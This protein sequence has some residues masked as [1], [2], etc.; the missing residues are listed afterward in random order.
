MRRLAVL[1]LLGLACSAY[2][3]HAEPPLDEITRDVPSR[4]VAWATPLRGGPIRA[5]FFA[6]DYTMRDAVELAE[7][8]DLDMESCPLKNGTPHEARAAVLPK[9]LGRRFDVILL[10]QCDPDQLPEA[11]QARIV[12]QVRQGAGL[13]VSFLSGEEAAPGAHAVLR[14][15]LRDLSWTAE[16]GEL[17]RGVGE[18]L[19]AGGTDLRAAGR[20][21]LAEKGRVVQ[22]EYPGDP[23]RTHA[24]IPVPL[25]P[26]DAAP[27]YLDNAFSFVAR[28]VCWAARR[29]APVRI[30]GVTDLTPQG[31]VAEEIPPGYPKEF[32][33]Q[34][35]DSAMRQ[36]T[37]PYLLHFNQPADRA[38][39]VTVQLRR[40]DALT[41]LAY[42]CKTLVAKG[43]ST[44]AVD[45]LA[46]P[47]EY[48]LD[49][50]IGDKKGVADW[51]TQTI[52]VPG[53]PCFE[54][55]EYGKTYLLPNDALDITAKVRPIFNP[56]R[57]CTVYARV[58][59]PIG[60]A[61]TPGGR[62]LAEAQA[63]SAAEDGVVHLR[64]NLAD[65]IAPMVKVEVF[66]VEGEGKLFAEWILDS[67]DR[68]CRFLNVRLPKRDPALSLVAAAPN[69][70]EYNA[71]QYLEL[72]ARL[73]VDAVCAPASEAGLFHA[74]EIGLRF[75]PRFPSLA[76]GMTEADASSLPFPG[77][78][79]F[80]A[81]ESKGLVEGATRYWA[82]GSGYYA[83]ADPCGV[84]AFS[85]KTPPAS[86]L[87]GFREYLKRQYV[88]LAALES[89]WGTHYDSWEEPSPLDAQAARAAGRYA[90][91][92][93][94]QTYADS[95]LT[96]FAAFSREQI[97]SVDRDA[98]VG[99]QATPV[100]QARGAHPWTGL[101]RATDFLA[102]NLEPR[103]DAI[104][105]CGLREPGDTLA[106]VNAGKT[107]PDSPMEGRWLPWHAALHQIPALWMDTPFGEVDETPFNAALAADGRPTPFF[108][109]LSSSMEELTAG[110]AAL[111]QAAQRLPGG[112][113]LCE[114]RA[115][116]HLHDAEGR[117]MSPRDAQAR[118]AAALDRI[119][120]EYSVIDSGQLRERLAAAHVLILPMT[121]A[122]SD[123]EVA[124]ILEF[125][126]RGGCVVADVAPGVYNE[127][128]VPRANPPLDALFG[129]RHGR[130]TAPVHGEAEIAWSSGKKQ[131][132]TVLEQVE[133]DGAT[134]V[135]TGM[136]M[137]RAKETPVWIRAAGAPHLLLNHT[138]PDWER[139]GRGIELL[140]DVLAAAGAPPAFEIHTRGGRPFQG[141]RM[142]FRFGDAEIFAVLA[143]PS[144]PEQRIR[145]PFSK[146]ETVYDL[147]AG[148]RVHKPHKMTV[149]L[150]PGE[151]CCFA[152]L[153]YRVD[154]L[155]VVT[156]GGVLAGKRLP[157]KVALSAKEGW[158]SDHLVCIDLLPDKGSAIPHYRRC[159]RCGKGAGETFLPLA[160]N[161]TPG[162]YRLRVRDVLS[163]VEQ[164]R[165]VG[166]SGVKRQGG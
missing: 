39:R 75:I 82:G 106:L 86:C 4:H 95:E 56:N 62:L 165:R 26:V 10:G 120:V 93:D 135:E 58:M 83:M 102:V 21:A 161:E 104:Q 146:K 88:E 109:A 141:E 103:A 151:A 145:L 54:S 96:D 23:P 53:W 7:R 63:A 138:A 101:S 51:F 130:A 36:P 139:D 163:G 80:R 115:S 77:D 14:G 76:A 119:G 162:R 43:A 128:G 79:E 152:R 52:Q 78:P 147:R 133:P 18:F 159:V 71:Q 132:K 160:I 81:R 17:S 11:V 6:P 90:S 42:T 50:W 57:S 94:F 118:F 157:V 65:L 69:A 67:S 111:F 34:M 89:A 144:A 70:E 16:P 136:A 125:A 2:G 45:L 19:G 40:P 158:P 28:A 68:D 99:F 44:F 92:V 166:V 64:L 8:L 24:F 100:T 91:Y 105:L 33:A 35:R 38:Y 31:P 85:A 108:R 5:L 60:G 98:R 1:L 131:V 20:V 150:A 148:K 155:G 74:D 22:L 112:V 59:D 137:G 107:R 30:A 29:E 164:V 154:A 87:A 116:L 25:D 55:V 66:A 27:T 127:H 156:P 13:I 97:R 122:L 32:V 149:D 121:R 126:A 41:Q 110:L 123:A 12:E 142:R 143:D 114:S 37:R 113:Y 72:L 140:W 73:G 3:K 15:F 124:A 84:F 134:E 9:L 48:L 46:G 117:F 47:G 129:V 49:A 61:S 153:H